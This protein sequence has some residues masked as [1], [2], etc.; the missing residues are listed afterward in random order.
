MQQDFFVAARAGSGD[1]ALQNENPANLENHENPA[2][3]P[4]HILKILLLI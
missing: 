4:A 1:P 2:P 3:N